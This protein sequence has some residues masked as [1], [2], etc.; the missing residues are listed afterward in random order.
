LFN[1][2]EPARVEVGNLCCDGIDNLA[3][4]RPIGIQLQPFSVIKFQLDDR[5]HF[6]DAVEFLAANPVNFAPLN[7]GYLTLLILTPDAAIIGE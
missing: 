5:I 7:T 2:L 4:A 1:E 3:K 6:G